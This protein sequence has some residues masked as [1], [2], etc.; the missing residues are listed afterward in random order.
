MTKKSQDILFDIK[1]KISEIE[2]E[3]ESSEAKAQV[4]EAIKTMKEEIH[5]VSEE[6]Q[7]IDAESIAKE[8]NTTIKKFETAVDTRITEEM[9]K[10]EVQQA[11]TKFNDFV[12]QI[13]NSIKELKIDQSGETLEE[14]L[15][16]MVQEAELELNKINEHPIVKEL[17]DEF[18]SLEEQFK[19][20]TSKVD[21]KKIEK[22]IDSMLSKI[23]S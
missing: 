17:S 12:G 18:N 20:L 11:I 5:N 3:I 10:E 22:D 14:K 4:E 16:S 2:K 19:D 9:K 1:S 6:I 7:S 23:S 21:L 15:E 8:L 13:T